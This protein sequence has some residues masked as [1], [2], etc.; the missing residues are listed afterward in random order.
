MRKE[1]LTSLVRTRFLPKSRIILAVTVGCL[2]VGVTRAIVLACEEAQGGLMEKWV[3]P[4][5]DNNKLTV[6]VWYTKKKADRMKEIRFIEMIGDKDAGYND[7][8]LL[9]GPHKKIPANQLDG[10]VVW[11]ITKSD[12]PNIRIGT[13]SGCSSCHSNDPPTGGDLADWNDPTIY[14]TPT[15]QQFKDWLQGMADNGY[16]EYIDVA[17]GTG[18]KTLNLETVEQAQ[19][20]AEES[21][22][23][24]PHNHGAD[25]FFHLE[26]VDAIL[27]PGWLLSTQPPLGE[28]FFLAANEFLAGGAIIIQ[29]TGPI[30]EGD[31]AEVTVCIFSQNT[32][33]CSENETFHVRLGRDTEPPTFGEPAVGVVEC[34]IVVGITAQDPT[35]TVSGAKI[36]FQLDGRPEQS[37]YM[38]I[39]GGPSCD[40]VSFQYEIGPLAPGDHTLSY[41]IQIADELGNSDQ[42]PLQ[43]E[44]FTTNLTGDVNGDGVVN[45]LDLIDLLLCFGLPAVPECEAQDINGDGTVNVLDLIDLLLQFGVA[46]T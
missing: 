35:A 28:S 3:N 4:D 30:L 23:I 9:G 5:V 43:E 11:E 26:L 16:G 37:S 6:T 1:R 14:P 38:D 31:V 45:V 7:R 13:I 18:F 46:C 29:P 39:V 32:G 15:A 25:G 22:D 42:T 17:I 40:P 19:E 12:I 27:P 41:F 21:F 8:F 33:E 20:D 34:S 36:F 24:H 2:T 10:K 44:F